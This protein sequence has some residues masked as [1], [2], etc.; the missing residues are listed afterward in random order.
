[1]QYTDDGF[2]KRLK[3]L[4]QNR[5]YTQEQVAEALSIHRTTYTYYEKGRTNPPREVMHRLVKLFDVSYEELLTGEK[6][7]RSRVAE[8]GAET[9]KIYGLTHEELD[10]LRQIRSMTPE[11]R[12]EAAEYNES[13]LNRRSRP[14]AYRRMTGED[15]GTAE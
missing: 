8:S 13:I 12:R 6:A 14:S 3:T 1:M 9:E 7:V 5:G 15:T 10:I 4:R 11:E 2:A